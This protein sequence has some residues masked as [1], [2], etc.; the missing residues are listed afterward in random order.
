EVATGT[1]TITV[2]PSG[3]G[4]AAAFIDFESMMADD[5]VADGELEASADSGPEVEELLGNTEGEAPLQVRGAG[6]EIL[7][8]DGGGSAASTAPGVAMEIEQ[9]AIMREEDDLD[10]LLSQQASSP[11]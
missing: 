11:L 6:D 2:D 7:T 4:V 8:M 5:A 3:A 9:L 1:L 10:M